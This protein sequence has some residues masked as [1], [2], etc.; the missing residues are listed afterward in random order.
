MAAFELN[1]AIMREFRVGL[2]PRLRMPLRLVP[3]RYWAAAAALLL[4]AAAALA[5]RRGA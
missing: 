2:L 1:T 4:A 5:A 3:P